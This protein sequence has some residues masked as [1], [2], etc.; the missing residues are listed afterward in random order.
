MTSEELPAIPL[1]DALIETIASANA[2]DLLSDVGEVGIDRLL[3]EGPLHDVPILGGI[4]KT[5]KLGIAI[6]DRTFA[7]K[8]LR[9]LFQL[10]SVPHEER[11]A[12]AEKM[13]DADLRERVGDQLILSLDRLDDAEKANLLGLMFRAYVRD[14]VSY[15]EFNRLAAAIDR[16]RF[17]DLVALR[18]GLRLMRNP[19]LCWPARG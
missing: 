15:Q 7:K 12:F 17:A 1:E 2:L 3:M 5:A 9:F 18:D 6:R 16:A 10:Q 13:S 4:V 11:E 8:V 19:E 14:R